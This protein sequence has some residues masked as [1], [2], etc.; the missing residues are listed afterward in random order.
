MAGGLVRRTFVLVA[1]LSA[2]G[3]GASSGTVTA[4]ERSADGPAAALETPL[5][6]LTTEVE[7]VVPEAVTTMPPAVTT[8]TTA[9]P[10]APSTAPPTV[11]PT[12]TRPPV[13][14]VVVETGF[15]PY[16]TSEGVVLH[17]PAAVVERIGFHQSGHDG[18]R[19]QTAAAGAARAFTMESRDRGTGSQTAA[20]IVVAPDTELRAPVTGT[21]IRGGAYTLYCDHRDEYVVIEPDARPGWEVKLLHFEGLRVRTGDRV[22]G[23]VTVVGARGRVLPFSSQVDE[24]TAAPAWP[25]VHV[26]VVDPS[27]PDRPS[28]G[29]C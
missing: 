11:A 24:F 8:V 5:E 20:D 27:I 19:E 2:M 25:H 22:E 3:C 23:G 7:P 18:A 16:A 4:L 15:S 1:A 13:E 28:G 17:H 12:T 26:E 29:G 10:A 6:P 14:R 9:P 21:V